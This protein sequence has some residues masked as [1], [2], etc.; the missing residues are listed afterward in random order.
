MGSI[1]IMI[2]FHWGSCLDAEWFKQ[3]QVLKHTWWHNII[4]TFKLNSLDCKE[5]HLDEFQELLTQDEEL[6][7][8]D[9]VDE[10]V[11]V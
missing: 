3:L 6:I 5:V 1:G 8:W 2:N 7:T 10:V 11:K 4:N 9:K